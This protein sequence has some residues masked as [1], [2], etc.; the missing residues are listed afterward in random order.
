MDVDG[1]TVRIVPWPSYSDR[2]LEP[3]FMVNVC[4]PAGSFWPQHN[5][6]QFGRGSELA[7]MDRK[8][9]GLAEQVSRELVRRLGS[10]H[11]A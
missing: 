4:G 11:E 7:R 2:T 10:G 8:R 6:R 5:G 9:P 1:Y 3:W